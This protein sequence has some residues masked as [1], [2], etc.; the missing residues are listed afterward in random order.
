M[1][2]TKT[3]VSLLALVGSTIAL[4]VNSGGS[5][6]VRYPIHQSHYRRFS[7]LLAIPI[8]VTLCAT[9]VLRPLP[10]P[11]PSFFPLFAQVRHLVFLAAEGMETD[12]ATRAAIGHR[13]CRNERALVYFSRCVYEAINSWFFFPPL[14]FLLSFSSLSFPSQHKPYNTNADGKVSL[15]AVRKR[16]REARADTGDEQGKL[17]APLST[18]KPHLSEFFSF[19]IPLLFTML[20]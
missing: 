13:R 2:H 16:L 18:F 5:N 9:S 14:F 1:V 8:P 11:S 3:L 15:V 20:V 4:V 7:A 17:C 6:P 12:V 10:F 19:L